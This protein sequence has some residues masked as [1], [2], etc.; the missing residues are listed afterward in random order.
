MGSYL[1]RSC[2][3]V[4]GGPAGMVLGY[5]LSRAGIEVQILE[6]HADFLVPYPLC[7]HRSSPRTGENT[8][9]LQSQLHRTAFSTGCGG[10]G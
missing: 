9:R 6:K 4:G 2:C 5:L 7:L 3:I 1:W 10:R 8:R